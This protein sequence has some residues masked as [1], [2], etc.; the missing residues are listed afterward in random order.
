MSKALKA[1][2]ENQQLVNDKENKQKS[3]GGD[4]AKGRLLANFTV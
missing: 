4:V 1:I 2:K 3:Y